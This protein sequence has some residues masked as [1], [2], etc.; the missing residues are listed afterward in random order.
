MDFPKTYDPKE[1]EEKIY[2]LWEKSGFF[3]PD[4]LPKEH[5]KPYT[6]VVPPPNVTGELHMGHALNATIQDTLI[7]WKRM[8]GFKTLWLPGT[9]HAG[10]ATQNVVEKK[11]K[12]EGK[13]RFDLGRSNFVK[14]VWKWKEKYGDIILNQF[15]RMG[16]SLDWSRTTFTMDQN[17]AEAVKTA[18][19][20]Y[21]KKG[22]I[23]KGKRVINWCPRCQTSLSD[24]EVERKEKETNLWYIKY[25]IAGE[26]GSITVATT[27]PE[28][29][30]GDTA[31]AV[32][33][34]DK[35]HKK[36]IGKKAVLPL[37]NKEIPIIADRLI[38][39]EF[40]TGAVKVTPAHSFVDFEIAQK[41]KLEII[42][43]INEKGEITESAPLP[44]QGMKTKEA[45][46]KVVEDLEKNNFLE[47][48]EKHVH[49]TPRC[50][51]CGS[52]V[53]LLPSEQWFLKM[54]ELAKKAKKQV[55]EGKIKFTPKRW[56]KV[57]FNWLDNIRDWCISRQLW[58][59][60][61]LPVWECQ[62]KKGKYFLS[63]KEPKKCL[64]CGKC[65]PK[66]TTDVL[67][68]WFSSALWPF[69]TL[70]WPKKTKDLKTFYPT[71]TLSTD[72]GIINLWVARMIF[73]GMEF[74]KK[75]PFDKVYIHAT[76][77]T[78]DGRRMSKSLGTGINPM[79]LIEKYGADA[80]RFGLSYQIT[81]LQDMK[82]SEDNIIMGKKFCNKIWNA[83]RF[84]LQ[85]I[86]ESKFSVKNLKP[87]EIK[88]KS[89]KKT[90]KSLEKIINTVDKDIEKFQL[91]KACHSL[92]DFFW[93]NFCDKC[94]E[95][96][97]ERKEDEETQRVLLYTLLTCLKILHP[98]IPFLT[99]SIY[100]NLPLKDKK[101]CLMV[102]KWPS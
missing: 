16:S 1:S 2:K 76:V 61:K 78:K 43:V 24:L 95:E 17:Y 83:S 40:G 18:F 89:N 87:K 64:V 58:W 67:D 45:R 86:P 68:T 57:Y 79:T 36:L 82:F 84:V 3:N 98:F 99:E 72:R 11:L 56:E 42:Q 49:Q 5:K 81:E 63:E 70:G 7:R 30:L 75:I 44:Y 94:I 51:R 52:L 28:T 10:I 59:G 47:K 48:T 12:K 62:N 65:N 101:K 69:A 35:R 55:K 33:P 31:V 8:K 91:G 20:N 26:P 92:Y 29:M 73:S 102:E 50:E 96:A 38:D 9:D 74:M 71:N 13:T 77:L 19:S 100:Q 46:E 14:E 53:E 32:N 22:W 41:H 97:K 66:Q 60:H 37:V 25:P 93:H 34:K 54:D 80:T 90:I 21:Y 15:K 88:N 23:Y 27:R 4:K 6:I 39:T 85:Q